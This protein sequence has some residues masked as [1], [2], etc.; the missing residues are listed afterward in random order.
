MDG[1]LLTADLLLKYRNAIRKGYN[2]GLDRALQKPYDYPRNR[3]TVKGI[4]S[5]IKRINDKQD[6]LLREWET[7]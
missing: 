1:H 5:Y 6:E 2:H 7:N 4:E 3:N